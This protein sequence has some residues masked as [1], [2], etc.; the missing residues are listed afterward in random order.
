MTLGVLYYI[1]LIKLLNIKNGGIMIIEDIVK[2]FIFIAIFFGVLMVCQEP[3]SESESYQQ[4]VET[5]EKILGVF[6]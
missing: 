4:G 3:L 1:I 5:R 2:F 6:D